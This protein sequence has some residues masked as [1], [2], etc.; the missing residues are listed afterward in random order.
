MKYHQCM[1]SYLYYELFSQNVNYFTWWPKQI[2]KNDKTEEKN[3][4]LLCPGTKGVLP[5][6][7]F[8]FQRIFSK[9]TIW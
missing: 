8:L 1:T 5:H 9:S 2:L 6:F 7:K 4:T 3:K